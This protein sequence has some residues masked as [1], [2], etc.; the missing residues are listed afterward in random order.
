MNIAQEKSNA[1]ETK[2][3]IISRATAPIEPSFPQMTILVPLFAVLGLFVGVGSAYIIEK[4]ED[5]FYSAEDVEA[6][7]GVP[8]LSEF[9]R[10]VPVGNSQKQNLLLARLLKEEPRGPYSEAVR[11][12]HVSDEDVSRRPVQTRHRSYIVTSVRRQ[13][14]HC[15]F[16]RRHRQV[17]CC[18]RARSAKAEHWQAARNQ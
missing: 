16:A 11:T 13:K 17:C 7:L 12:L 14:R 2:A 5:A 15:P 9:P 18:G 4:T 6:M 3:R 8:V 1:G 10:I